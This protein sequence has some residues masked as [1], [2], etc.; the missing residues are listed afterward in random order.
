MSG[1]NPGL[2]TLNNPQNAELLR[3]L[4][5]AYRA[6]SAIRPTGMP[7]L[8]AGSTFRQAIRRSR[9]A[10][11]LMEALARIGISLPSSQ[12][13]IEYPEAEE[14]QDMAIPLRRQLR[15]LPNGSL[16]SM[17]LS[18]YDAYLNQTEIL[19]VPGNQPYPSGRTPV[20]NPWLRLVHPRAGFALEGFPVVQETGTEKFFISA[21]FYTAG[22]NAYW[23]LYKPNASYTRVEFL[24]YITG[25]NIPTYNDSA[26]P[27]GVNPPVTYL[28]TPLPIP[29]VPP[30]PT[31]QEPNQNPST[32]PDSPTRRPVAPPLPVPF[33]RPRPTSP[34]WNNPGRTVRPS[35]SR[36]PST[37]RVP[38]VNPIP[39]E[40]PSTPIPV[41][42]IFPPLPS[43]HPRVP[44]F[45]PT[46]SPVPTQPVPQP[47]EVPNSV[48]PP[49]GQPLPV[50]TPTTVTPAPVTS[51]PPT[52]PPPP[53]IPPVGG[54]NPCSS[55]G[56]CQSAM[57]DQIGNALAQLAAMLLA[58]NALSNNNNS[59]EPSEVNLDAVLNKLGRRTPLSVE[60]MIDL[61][62]NNLAKINANTA[63][64][65]AA[66]LHNSAQLS[67]TSVT[68][69]PS[70][71]QGITNSLNQGILK[72]DSSN[73]TAYTNQVGFVR[74]QLS[75]FGGI[76][77]E[78]NLSET[79]SQGNRLAILASNLYYDSITNIGAVIKGINHILRI[80]TF[81]TNTFIQTGKLNAPDIKLESDEINIASA[82]IRA[83]DDSL[84]NET[85]IESE[86]YYLTSIN[87]LQTNSEVVSAYNTYSTN[88]QTEIDTRVDELTEDR[89]ELLEESESI[90]ITEID[91]YS[92]DL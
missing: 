42:R 41:T 5:G 11:R 3:S 14:R 35:T 55:A 78:G 58:L 16:V 62:S 18:A 65:I 48:M 31:P 70:N 19:Y 80:L 91:M 25:N 40:I 30:Q 52:M 7:P 73:A 34:T 69:I 85:P 23:G 15:D 37:P 51:T 43:I 87:T 12:P 46:P 56:G 82:N 29:V 88:L 77:A 24:H 20:R 2:S 71:I 26:V 8:P 61:Q 89:T 81:T 54:S 72:V 60:D 92:P 1:N 38:S 10:L 44:I 45:E 64:G 66:S 79:A 47:L 36:T 13:T 33:T 86:Q 83:L 39:T 4:E 68:A 21:E 49:I 17:V 28:P 22:N 90:P 53:T 57:Y 32:P 74:S 63:I 27:I 75:T 84:T 50:N 9:F 59:G 6:P 76:D 67:K